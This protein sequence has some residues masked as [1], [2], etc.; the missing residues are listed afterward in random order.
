METVN[1]QLAGGARQVGMEGQ[2]DGVH[3]QIGH[4]C[5]F[6]L[7]CPPSSVKGGREGLTSKIPNANQSTKQHPHKHQ[8]GSLVFSSQDPVSIRVTARCSITLNEAHRLHSIND[9]LPVYRF[10]NFYISCNCLQGAADARRRARRRIFELQVPDNKADAV[11]CN[12]LQFFPDD[13]Q[14]QDSG[15]EKQQGRRHRHSRNMGAGHRKFVVLNIR[16]ITQGRKGDR[17]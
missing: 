7:K 13:P 12:W 14:T 2:V 11:P 10:P 6:G 5:N 16:Y 1:R 9:T 17:I 15:S 4:F 8:T 3:E